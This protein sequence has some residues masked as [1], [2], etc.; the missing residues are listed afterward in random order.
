MGWLLSSACAQRRLGPQWRGLVRRNDQ[1]F[2]DAQGR[3]W[4][5]PYRW[6]CTLLAVR[7]DLLAR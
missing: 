1:G 4:A 3:V 6:G 7:A 2:P 5:A